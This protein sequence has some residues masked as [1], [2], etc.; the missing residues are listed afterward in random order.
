MSYIKTHRVWAIECK[1]LVNIIQAIR[2][3]KYVY[4]MLLVD[5]MRIILHIALI[6]SPILQG[7][8]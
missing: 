1:R 8:L 7:L 5:A 6:N 3:E 4:Y 2:E